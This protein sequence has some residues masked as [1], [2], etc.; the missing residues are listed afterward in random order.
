[1]IGN[2]LKT[3]AQVVNGKVHY[4]F[5]GADMTQWNENQITVADITA[6]SPSPSVGWL[7]TLTGGSWF[8]TPPSVAAPTT[9]DLIAALAT[10]LSDAENAGIFFQPTGA[11]AP[12]LWPSTDAALVRFTAIWN[13]ITALLWV[14]GTP[15]ISSNGTPVPLSIDDA[16]ALI[17]KA[18]GYITACA[19]HY[20]TLHAAVLADHATDISVGWP[21]NT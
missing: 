12:I 7:A 20:A 15:L 9:S 10:R 18:L 19:A 11:P 14:D 6:T 13:A 1:M 4:I 5:T 21:L 3:Y 2:P 8:F 16:K 17:T